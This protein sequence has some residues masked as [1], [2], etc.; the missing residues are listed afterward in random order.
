MLKMIRANIQRYGRHLYNVMGEESPRVLYTI[1]L[2]EK[3]GLEIVLA[4]CVAVPVQVAA[5][6]VNRIGGA[7]EEGVPPEELSL[8]LSS[9]FGSFRLGPV[10]PSWSQR[11]LLGALDYYGLSHIKAFQVLPEPEKRSIDV[12]DMTIPF[13]PTTHPVWKWF[14]EKWPYHIEPHCRVI[15]NLDALRGRAVSDIF[16]TGEREWDMI[17][18]VAPEI[19]VDQFLH[20]PLALLLAYDA[21]L[22]VALTIPLG[23][24]LFREYDSQGVLGPWK[25][26]PPGE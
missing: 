9:T 7:L 24:G 3:V 22:E 5:E 12:P 4:G 18:G 26:R 14:E 10:H 19:P 15:T 11:L 20:V 2:H 6:L 16:R 25:P 13:S 8:A 21:E 23:T 17:S 1:G